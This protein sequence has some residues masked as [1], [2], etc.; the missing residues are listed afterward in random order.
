MSKWKPQTLEDKLIDAYWKKNGRGMLYLEVPV[1]NRVA[2]PW[3]KGSKVRRIDA[4]RVVSEG[5]Q[6]DEVMPRKAYKLPDLEKIFNGAEVEVIEAKRRLNRAGFGQAVSGADMFE[7]QY[8]PWIVTPVVIYEIG[9]LAL[10]WVCRKHGVTTWQ[11][12][13]TK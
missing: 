9:D 13:V 3:K 4:V 1:G 6:Q 2:G 12:N 11:K 7:M 8:H 10:E 5:A